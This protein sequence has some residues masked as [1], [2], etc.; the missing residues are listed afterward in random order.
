MFFSF[1]GGGI[2]VVFSEQIS[3]KPVANNTAL[4]SI[5]LLSSS[6]F[7]SRSYVYRLRF[8]CS[9]NATANTGSIVLPN[10]TALSG[11]YLNYREVIPPPSGIYTCQMRDSN[12]LLV[13]MSIGVSTP[14]C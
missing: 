8:L 5:R 7:S 14:L 13:E 12:G 2:F 1:L 6:S 4:A 10:G 9:T 3:Y 11:L